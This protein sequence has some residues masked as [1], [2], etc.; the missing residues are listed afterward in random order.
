MSDLLVRGPAGTGFDMLVWN[1]GATVLPR[2]TVVMFEATT[3]DVKTT[4]T[5]NIDPGASGPFAQAASVPVI[6]V[7]IVTAVSDQVAGV[8]LD[9]LPAGEWGMIRIWG[10]VLAKCAETATDAHLTAYGLSTTDGQ[11]AEVAPGGAA[12]IWAGQIGA[13]GVTTA[14]DLRYVFVNALVPNREDMDDGVLQPM[15]TYI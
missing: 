5:P 1:G 3:T 2:G 14:G 8:V 7:V 15:G 10:P 4:I 11:L 12:N 9:D 6:G 13:S